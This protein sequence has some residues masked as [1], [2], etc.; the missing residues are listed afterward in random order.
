MLQRILYTCRPSGATANGNGCGVYGQPH[1]SI[2]QGKEEYYRARFSDKAGQDAPPTGVVVYGGQCAAPTEGGSVGGQDVPPTGAVV[3]AGKDEPLTQGA[4]NSVD[5]PSL[6]EPP[7][8]GAQRDGN[9]DQI[10][11]RRV[12]QQGGTAESYHLVVEE[13]FD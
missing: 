3:G 5:S 7:L 4:A 10:N 9:E 6:I 1:P 8:D 11:P 13:V 12:T 2:G